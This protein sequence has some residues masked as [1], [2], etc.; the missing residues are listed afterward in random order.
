MEKIKNIEELYYTIIPYQAIHLDRSDIDDVASKLL[1]R[2]LER[3]I[4]IR[5]ER[6][7]F[8]DWGFVVVSGELITEKELEILYGI[9]G[10]DDDEKDRN[11]LINGHICTLSQSLSDR[12][13]V[14]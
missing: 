11:I 5:I 8:Y 13:S 14:V 2:L 6:S 4:T 10:A 7:E 3:E 9:S 12:K 1:S